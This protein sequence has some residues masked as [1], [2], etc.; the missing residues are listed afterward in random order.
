MHAPDEAVLELAVD[1]WTPSVPRGSLSNSDDLLGSLSFDLGE[2]LVEGNVLAPALQHTFSVAFRR[3]WLEAIEATLAGN[4]LAGLVELAHHREIVGRQDR[5]EGLLEEILEVNRQHVADAR[6]A[7]GGGGRPLG[8]DSLAKAAGRRV[9]FYSYAHEDRGHL[10]QLR[11]AMC[12]EHADFDGLEFWADEAIPPAA[13]WQRTI[14]TKLRSAVC[15][16]MPVSR[17]LLASKFVMKVELPTLEALGIPVY[18][19]LLTDCQWEMHDPFAKQ[20]AVVAPEH[21]KLALHSNNVGV[22][23]QALA[24][25]ARA[26]HG[27]MLAHSP[28]QN[29]PNAVAPAVEAGPA[30]P[31]GRA[32]PTVAVPSNG[33]GLGPL[34]GVPELPSRFVPRPTDLERARVALLAGNGRAGLVAGSSAALTGEGGRGKSVLAAALARDETV[35]SHFPGGVLWVSVGEERSGLDAQSQMASHLDDE[36][37]WPNATAG[38]EQLTQTLA[39]RPPTLVIADDVWT[40]AQLAAIDPGQRTG[41][42]GSAGSLL[43]TT[44][45]PAIL[46]PHHIPCVP[47]KQLTETAALQFLAAQADCPRDELPPE[48]GQAIEAVGRGPLALAVLG[49][50]IRGGMGW[51]ELADRL[52]SLRDAYG[53][54][55]YANE[56][57]AFQLGLERLDTGQLRRARSLAVF[58]E[59]VDV[60]HETLARYWGVTLTEASTYLADL[61]GGLANTTDT[62]LTLHDL[63]RGFLL[64]G[65]AQPSL[66]HEQLLE[67]HRP[68]TNGGGW[69]KLPDE[70][71]YLWEHLT[72]HLIGAG[73]RRDLIETFS[74]LRYLAK[75][76]TRRGSRVHRDLVR[77]NA[78]VGSNGPLADITKRSAQVMTAAVGLPRTEAAETLAHWMGGT[79]GLAAVADRSRLDSMLAPTRLAAHMPLGALCAPAVSTSTAHSGWVWSVAWNHD[80]SRLATGG[81]DGTLRVWDP[82]NPDDA[83][84]ISDAHNG[85]LV[86]VAWNHDGTR[87]ATVGEDGKLRVW[88]P[89]NPDD[90]VST[91]DA[92]TGALASVA[93]N[94]DGTRLA[95]GGADGTLRVWDP[96]NPDDA[97][98]ASDAHN[99]W[100][101]S[102]AWNQDGTRLVTGGDDGTL[103]VWDPTNPDDAVS[104]SAARNGIVRSVAWN[105]DGSRL[106]TV[107]EDGKLR[108]WDPTNPDDAVSTSDAHTGAGRSVAWNHDG[109]RLAT[110]GTDGKL[111]VWDPT[112]PDDAVSTSSAH[113]G[114][115]RS[116]AWNHDGTR[117]ATGGTDGKLRVWDPTN[118]DDAAPTSNAHNGSVRSVAWNHDG[119]R[120]ATGGADGKLR[121]WDP[122]N[123]DDAISTSNAR[124][125]WVWSVAWNHDGS[126]LATGGDDGKLRVWDPTNPDDAMST[127]TAHEGWVRSVAWNDDG[128]DGRTRV[129]DPTNPVDAV[130]TSKAHTG[131]VA[132]VGWND[133]GIVRS[134]AWNHDGSRLATGGGDG[135]LRVW[136]PTNPDDA[137]WTSDAHNG[138]VWSVAWNHDGSR[139]ATGGDDGIL[140]VWDPTNPDDAV[141]TSNARNGAVRSVAWN[142]DGTRLATGGTD[143]KLRVWD[144]TNPDDA[145][146]A[147]DA[148]N[149][150]V[151]SVAWNHDGTRLVTG[152]DDGKLRVWDPVNPERALLGVGFLAAVLDVQWGGQLLGVASGTSFTILEMV[153]GRADFDEQAGGA[154]PSAN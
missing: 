31:S 95:T 131:A 126:Q 22:R 12:E 70:E 130:S 58:P 132:S 115:V 118:P 7:V 79:P 87:L 5:S 154:E 124:N 56:F 92:H 63:Q 100:V 85:A 71:P 143:G 54:H 109:S 43:V 18:W 73:D 84:S 81:T 111:R 104:T 33:A 24:A 150:W 120:L 80:G 137:V 23:E 90:A 74:D 11:G 25:V 152:G 136:D 17:Y 139:L 114:V 39:Q 98:S 151:W 37:T 44:R 20:K 112:N 105:H 30:P 127:S 117:L 77:A 153:D 47:V 123:P 94:H 91:S 1:A 13:E 83:V 15:A 144:P 108:V 86:S 19:Y 6:A 52:A 134:V 38:I 3:S 50:A 128:V 14:D 102:V 67:T 34:L 51:N 46:R 60:P 41:E 101:W 82:T 141:S 32:T 29:P 138:W 113:S 106:A 64:M 148:H 53:D 40:T 107:G 59:D 146:S 35:R 78:S 8:S 26:L 149:G 116:V 69:A 21:T 61:G 75:A 9:V 142:H 36:P 140:R 135:K 96:S 45:H 88:D 125:G 28:Q 16:I 2:Q 62:H 49:G 103:R 10:T 110:G 147:S 55:P 121:V 129:W 65:V 133:D 76:V 48:V 72:E 66:L 68:L 42:A 99:G 97:I 119:T 57:K 27:S 93:W 145:M 89:T 4:D 122:T